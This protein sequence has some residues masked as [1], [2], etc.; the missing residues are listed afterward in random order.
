MP[1]FITDWPGK[2]APE[3]GIAHPAA[4]HMLDVAAVA[5]RLIAPFALP[6]PLTDA[7]VLL[8]ALHDLGKISASFR[9]ML[10]EGKPQPFG[11]HWQMTEVLLHRHDARLAA[12]LGG[13]RPLR[14][15]LYAGTAGHHGGPPTLNLGDPR[16]DV[17]I[18]A[19]ARADSGALIDAFAAFWPGAAL[20]GLG[21]EDALALSYWLPGLVA[22]A[23]WVGS[24]PVWFPPRLPA[25]DLAAY[26]AEARALA[27]RAVDEAGLTPVPPADTPLLDPAW[28]L[29]PMQAACAEVPLPDGA[30]LVV[31]E[32][33]TGA[34]KTEAALMLAQR[35]MLAGKGRGL[36]LALPTTATADAMFR[37]ARA[38]VRRLFAAP[39]SLT[40]AHGRAALSQD[41]RALRSPRAA[42][43][44]APVCTEWLADNRR[45]A[46][47]GTVGVGTVDQALL[48]ILP[49]R[50]ATLRHFAL[51]SKI[52]IIDE[53]HEM[54]APYMA[55]ELAQLL[56]AHR[57]AGG[58][59][60]LLTATL[61][62]DQ[63]RALLAAWGAA[64][65][66]DPAYPAL[67]MAGGATRRDLP[68]ATGAR[69]PV[70]VQRLA[71]EDEAR[72][73][74]AVA[75]GQGAACLWVRNA[76]DDAIA[77]VKAL[78]QRGVTADLLHARFAL[79]DR[80]RHEEAALARFGKTGQGR[81][82]RVLVA[83]QVVE[84]SLD[85]DFDVMVSDLAPVAAL[86]QRA[87]RLWRHMD[88]RPAPSRPAPAPVLHVLSPDPAQVDDDQW[89]HRV[90]D[91]GAWV[92]PL[93]LQWRAA[94]TVFA[95]A[96][97]VAPS[98]LRA[99]IEAGHGD[100]GP[101]LPDPLTRA[102]QQRIAM[103]Y[104]EANHARRNMVD[105]S[106][107]YRQGGAAA[108]DTDYPT[109]L[110]RPT[111]T[112]MLA[113]RGPDGLTPYDAGE[114]LEAAQRSE[115][116]VAEHRLQGLTL[117]DQAAPEIAALK[118][119]W[120]EWRRAS[121]TVCPLGADGAICEGLRYD[122]DEGVVFGG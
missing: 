78:R 89:L 18:G 94:R 87:G 7:L 53:I 57:Q 4:C 118:A 64:D 99:L 62:L 73:L 80:L 101:A 111:R 68:Q 100:D 30:T 76:V 31:I 90:L 112:L 84:S 66:G 48:A 41:F 34:G 3:G 52:L 39:P 91:R 108:E 29:R 60:I 5:E 20:E 13:D 74:L 86:V 6:L 55:T 10:T 40:L 95:A 110:G 56:R 113:R 17:V 115:V 88:L 35:M 120:P 22:A 50:F 11:R 121:V 96:Q 92:Y 82:G 46:L 81:A 72:T 54:G 59:A 33:E 44:D 16:L 105:L 12:V 119:D 61:P 38:L 122:P 27:G 67:T 28:Q 32:D 70:A 107:G 109:R 75:A 116:Q 15:L 23:D 77:A 36:F 21:Y 117:P 1:R 83:T 102:E 14:N 103:G 45:R 65:D 24:N 98:G 93:D 69:G 85:L 49:T 47:L 8:T 104:A 51:S 97:I 63:R 9:A 25:T 79:T 19:A 43:T 71:S 114:G 58:S 42:P 37:R 26:L 2:S 106:K